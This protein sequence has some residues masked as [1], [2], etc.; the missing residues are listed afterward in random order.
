M[1]AIKDF[2]CVAD[3]KSDH[4]V[5][6]FIGDGILMKKDLRMDVKEELELEIWLKAMDSDGLVFYWTNLDATTGRYT[7]SDFVALVLVASQPHFFWNLGSGIA[8]SR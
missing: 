8:Y 6:L 4:T 3:A 7:D 1:R 2:K 5:P